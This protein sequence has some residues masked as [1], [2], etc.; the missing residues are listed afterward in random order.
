MSQKII[1]L[2]SLTPMLIL[3]SMSLN[4]AGENNDMW[5]FVLF[6]IFFCIPY[7]MWVYEATT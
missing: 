7:F 1:A 6:F 4:F 5:G 2:I 3:I